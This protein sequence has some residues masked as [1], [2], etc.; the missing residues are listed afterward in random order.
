M[1]GNLKAPVWIIP[2]LVMVM[3]IGAFAAVVALN[4]STAGPTEASNIDGMEY[5]GSELPG[6][7]LVGITHSTT[8]SVS[9]LTGSVFP[10]DPGDPTR[11]RVD[12]TVSGTATGGP[13]FAT[14]ADID[15]GGL[16][17]GDEIIITLEDDFGFVVETPMV[18][19]RITIAASIVTNDPTGASVAGQTVTPDGVNVDF[20]GDENDLLQI[21]VTV[22]D[23]GTADGSGSNGIADGAV[24]TVIFH[25]GAGVVNGRE[26]NDYGTDVRT[27]EDVVNADFDLNVV[28]RLLL[29][30]DDDDRGSKEPLFVL[31]IEGKESATIWLDYDGD[32]KRDAGERDLCNFIA[33]ADD[34]GQ[35]TIILNN[36]PF[37]PGSFG[38]GGNCTLP[39][40]VNCNFINFVGSEGRTTGYPLALTQAQVD[41]QTMKLLGYINISPK[42]ASV[43]D[44]VTVS[45]FDYP[46]LAPIDLIQVLKGLNISPSKLPLLT[47]PAGEVS[48]GWTIPGVAPTCIPFGTGTAVNSTA[49]LEGAI[50]AA[51]LTLAVETGQGTNFAAGMII[52]IDSER[53]KV[54][55]ISTDTLTVTRADTTTT[56]ATHADDAQID[57]MSSLTCIAGLGD[58]NPRAGERIPQGKLRVDIKSGTSTITSADNSGTVASFNLTLKGANLSL[59]HETVIANQDLTI[60]GSGFSEGTTNCIFEG[61]ITIGNVPVQ[62]DDASD[63]PAATLAAST[64]AT[65]PT[66]GILLTTGGTFTITVRV[67]DVDIAGTTSILSSTLLNEAIHELKVIDSNGAEGTLL[68]TIAERT[69]EVTPASARPRDVVTIIGRNFISDNQ[70]GLSTTVSVKYDCGS[71]SRTVTADPDVSGN[72]RETLRIPSG[73]AIPSTNTLSAEISADSKTTG[74]IET[75][76]HEIPEGLIT[77]EPGR[78]ASGSRITL[79][80]EGFRTFETVAKVEFGGLGTLGGRT[81]NTD[82]NGDFVIEGLQVPGLDPGIHAVK[83]E[84]STGSNRTTSST[85]FEVMATGLIG[86]PTP[87]EEVYAMSDSLL[88]IFWYDNS[89]KEWLF[90]DRNPDF[91]DV[92]DLDEMVSG[93]VYWIL[94]N[95]DVTLDVVGALIELTCIGDN[96]WNLITW[97]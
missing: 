87:V 90:N 11:F 14:A 16:Q 41:R 26:A 59:S 9:S 56:A 50:T 27:T 60:S 15:E 93:G 85:S 28:A 55:S 30:D 94:V 75:V 6:D 45:L 25:Q 78:G 70:D 37:F 67:H 88:R 20:A 68:V 65:L 24:V 32:G 76:T 43:G 66:S 97:P 3:A 74:V 54:V 36:P 21:T 40:L 84:V 81:V 82:G 39:V 63:C 64:L 46:S 23:M 33:D 1:K 4:H 89:S 44:T 91:A 49:D 42:T 35:C 5:T 69:L 71:T 34:T 48:F 52:K 58:N 8:S 72:F 22:P 95:S 92:N 62:I 53:I 73:C 7:A 47:G 77:I 17:P 61:Q 83:V 10:D 38:T 12:F 51:A 96:C 86:E 80:G 19:S 57:I 2:V 29:K 13:L 79:H 31:G 18:L